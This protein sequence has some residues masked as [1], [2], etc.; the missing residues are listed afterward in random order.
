MRILG[1]ADRF[2]ASCVAPV[3]FKSVVTESSD[4]TSRR[5][6]TPAPLNCTVAR[7]LHGLF[8][9]TRYASRQPD[10]KIAIQSAHGEF[11]VVVELN[12]GEEIC[13]SFDHLLGFAATISFRTLLD[14]SIP[15]W[16]IGRQVVNIATGP[17]QLYFR[18]AGRPM[19]WDNQNALSDTQR[20][21]SGRLVLWPRNAEFRTE[22][23]ESL[24][25]VWF[26]EI[27]VFMKCEGTT[28][29]VVL[30][31]E[32]KRGHDNPLWSLIS[33]LYRFW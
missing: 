21:Q 5:L 3:H 24:L 15:S 25:D 19:I 22:P 1:V 20:I 9:T 8:L 11:I 23:L 12:A 33:R 28:P 31:V 27:R 30:D 16:A 6:A 26:G 4:N 18:C 32:Q 29:F 14:W 17:G 10:A 7:L 2:E 13:I